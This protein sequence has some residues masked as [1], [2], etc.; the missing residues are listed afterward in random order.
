MENRLSELMYQTASNKGW[1]KL[2]KELVTRQA[3][4]KYAKEFNF[5]VS[6]TNLLGIIPKRQ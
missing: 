4:K 5:Y 2:Y 6:L 3:F 1:N